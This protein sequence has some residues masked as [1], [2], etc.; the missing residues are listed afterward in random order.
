MK[1]YGKNFELGPLE[2]KIMQLMWER[3]SS[4]V[5]EIHAILLD[6]KERKITTISTTMN[7]LFKKGLLS[8]EI[9]TG[10]TGPI[11]R[12]TIKKTENGF[13]EK[14]SK[15]LADQIIKSYG[16]TASMKVIQ[17]ISKNYNEEEFDKLLEELEKLKQL[18]DGE[19]NSN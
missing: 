6:E 10:K 17:E 16:H 2:L 12:Y 11:Y 3:K 8:R 14:L 9:T 15:N 18:K 5:G 1:Y 7:R 13:R 4:T 19:S